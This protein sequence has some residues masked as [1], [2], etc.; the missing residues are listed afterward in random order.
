MECL[1]RGLWNH[2]PAMP[3][4][5]ELGIKRVRLQS[6]WA[7]TE[8][9]KGKYDFAWLD[10][11]VADLSAI[12]VEPWISLSY[13]NPLYAVPEEGKQ[14]Y[15]GQTMFPMRSEQGLAAWLAYVTATVTRYKD[16]VRIWEIWNEPDFS[17]FLNVPKGS[18]WAT[19]YARLVRVT[20]GRIRAIQ[21]EARI[22]ACTAGGPVGGER[23]SAAL[24]EQGIADCVDIYTF[25][26]YRDIPEKMTPGVGAAFYS[27]VRSHAPKVAFWRG[28]AGISSVNTGGG[29]LSH[30]PLSEEMQARWMSRNLVRDLA[31]PN[32]SFTSWFH[33]SAF[34]H[35]SHERIYHYG[36]LREKD[37]SRKPSFY[38]LK[39]IRQFFDDG[40][41]APDATA[42]LSLWVSSKAP[43]ETQVL[44]SGA[45]VYAFRRNGLPLF[46]VTALWPSQEAMNP[47]KVGSTMFSGD[48]SGT[49]KDPVLYDLLDGTVRRLNPSP[50]GT[51]VFF[52]LANH[53]RIV[54]E[55]AAL[56]PYVKLPPRKTPVATP[57]AK[58][59]QVHHE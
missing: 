8:K 7:R 42:S 30:L 39:R 21:P 27:A 10:Q 56:A 9:E 45:A 53:I 31:D 28:E 52:D 46:A 38:V 3:Y 25:H 17:G 22:A 57:P 13:G 47:V 2:V 20:S 50:D 58:A 16:R 59:G 43:P 14:S 4:L 36:V 48:S 40:H 23:R 1:D 26:A 12:R 24:F 15:T 35:F 44:V 49:W 33:L 18:D 5:K 19:E 6:G 41:C 34:E 37:Y 54:T 51:R 29:A 32:I 55:A 11:I